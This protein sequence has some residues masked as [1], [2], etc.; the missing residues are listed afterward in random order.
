[1]DHIE[2]ALMPLVIGLISWLIKDL[3]VKTASKRNEAV[4][5][6]WEYRLKE[7]WSPLFYWSGIVI[8]SDSERG[9]KRHGLK[10]LGDILTKSAHLLP[11][12]HYHSLIRLLEGATDQKTSL[13][14]LDQIKNTRD[15]IY[16]QIELMNY[17]VYRHQ[18]M[19]EPD[20]AVDITKPY[21]LLLRG[22][23][24]VLFHLFIWGLIAGVLYTLYFCFTIDV[25]WPIIIF[26]AILII[27]VC[28]DLKKRI[29]IHR[30]IKK[31]VAD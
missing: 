7:I 31:R 2:Q 4:R 21:K 10:E 17:L 27:L 11:L 30:E 18:M 16:K 12:T 8:F 23:T 28:I 14:S 6:E 3:L 5:K 9:W 20:F 25:I 22:I 29:D 24:T 26:L 1:M 13:V 19:Y 15:Y